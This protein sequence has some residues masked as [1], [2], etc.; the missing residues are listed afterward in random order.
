MKKIMD[1]LVSPMEMS[2]STVQSLKLVSLPERWF[3]VEL[4]WLWICW[5]DQAAVPRGP[6]QCKKLG[7]FLGA[8]AAIAARGS[9]TRWAPVAGGIL[10][11]LQLLELL[12]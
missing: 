5:C 9:T 2:T 1:V 7:S 3:R 8:Q 11:F 6:Q 12:G 4:S 10:W